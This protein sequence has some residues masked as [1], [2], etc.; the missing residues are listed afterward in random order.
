MVNPIHNVS[1]FRSR[2]DPLDFD[3][4]PIPEA[5]P[6]A[7]ARHRRPSY[8]KGSPFHRFCNERCYRQ[9]FIPIIR[10]ARRNGYGKLVFDPFHE[11]IDNH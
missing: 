3:E 2:L 9:S 4:N 11:P 1:Y 8:G 6:A 10:P 5:D 7:S